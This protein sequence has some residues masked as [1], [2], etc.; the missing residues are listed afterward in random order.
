MNRLADL[1]RRFMDS[2][3]QPCNQVAGDLRAEGGIDAR[4]GL[5]VYSHAY[6]ARLREVL[7]N[8]H[9]ILSRYLGDALWA[10]L[11]VSYIA[12]HPSRFRSLRQFGDALPHFLTHHE[13]FKSH[14]EIAELAGFER[15]LLDSFD[16]PD[17]PIAAWVQLQALPGASWPGLRLQF[18]PS[19][20]RL[21]NGSNA[22]AVWIALK[23]GQAP[24]AAARTGSEWLCW[25]DAAMVT[26]FR[27][28]DC[29][30][31][32]LLDHFLGDGDFSSACELLLARHPADE[33][34][35]C[36]LGHLAR[37]TESGLVSD[38]IAG[39]V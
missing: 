18:L 1:Q 24:P 8:D 38:W 25:R 4:L 39:A 2:I 32:L 16:A 5:G 15:S 22:V 31:A 29:D 28:L 3:V 37:W 11:C 21:S 20:R 6:Q 17:A 35:A 34:P 13:S 27:S 26:Q 36:A 7:G 33:V 10:E 30:E 12:A 14:V 9:A 19:V 23:A